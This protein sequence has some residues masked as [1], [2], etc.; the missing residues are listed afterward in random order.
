MS[1]G[2]NRAKRI[3]DGI[4]RSSHVFGQCVT[5]LMMFLV[6][7]DVVMRHVF[8]QSIAGAF[9]VTELMMV[10]IVFLAFAYVELKDGHVRVDLVISLFPPRIRLYLE[11]VTAAI[12]VAMFSVLAWESAF[13]SVYLWQKGDLSGYLR[14][15]ISPF[16]M[17]ITFGCATTGLQLFFRLLRS[18]TQL[19]NEK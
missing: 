7:A 11:C 10:P 3:V 1:S 14:I 17:V 18:I 9:E 6:A 8:N 19:R 4:S 12:G 2:I 15:P 16:L 5:V 13:R